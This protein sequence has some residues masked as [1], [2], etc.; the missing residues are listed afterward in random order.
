MLFMW[1]SS[2]RKRVVVRAFYLRF[3]VAGPPKRHVLAPGCEHRGRFGR[4]GGTEQSLESQ[5]ANAG[6]ANRLTDGRLL[7]LKVQ[8]KQ[9]VL[10]HR[11]NTA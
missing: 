4:D 7:T 5:G 8:L 11:V 3:L 10:T 6:I 9:Y 1:P 2:R